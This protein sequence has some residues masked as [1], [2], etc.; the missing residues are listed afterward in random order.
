MS[1]QNLNLYSQKGCIGCKVCEGGGAAIGR[2]TL[3]W[4]IAFMTGGFGLLILPFFKKCM[5]CGH[6]TWLNSH[7]PRPPQA[8]QAPYPWTG[9]HQGSP[10]PPQVW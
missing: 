10:T 3:L 9:Q 6:N 5:F 8:P 2:T 7:Q 4:T 1:Q